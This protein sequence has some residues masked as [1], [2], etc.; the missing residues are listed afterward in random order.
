MLKEWLL[1][2]GKLGDIRVEE[3]F[4]KIA[5]TMETDQYVTMTILQ[6]EKEFGD[7]EEAQEFIAEI[8]KGQKG[9]PH[10]QAPTI[11]KARMYKVL[12]A[13]LDERR[14]G[15]RGEASASVGG[16]IQDPAAK[17][18]FAK[19]LASQTEKLE[20]MELVDRSTGKIVIPKPNKKPKPQTDDEKMVANFKALVTKL[21]D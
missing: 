21:L 15:S 16:S 4:V 8:C 20:G 7:S 9:T 18:A 1:N 12:K 5:E 3:K 14:R 2:D 10:P 6:M 17:A 13:L 19:T 11:K